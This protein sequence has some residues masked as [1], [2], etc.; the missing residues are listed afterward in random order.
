[1]VTR[2]EAFLD[3]LKGS[4]MNEKKAVTIH[5]PRPS[6]SAPPA[7][8]TL[9][10]PYMHDGAAFVAAAARSVGIPSEVLPKQTEVEIAL[11][12]KYTSSKECFPMICT[13]GSFLKKLM[14]PGADPSKM[15]FFMPDHNGPCR[16][17]QYNQF[18]RILFDRLGFKDAELVT[19]SNDTS[20]ADLAGDQSQK[21]RINAWKGF[22]SFDYVKKLYRKYDL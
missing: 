13:T 20:Y 9:Y 12:R 16:F 22:V 17:G 8:R 14:E 1:M 18:Q 19:P 15:S 5:R 11:G 6:P 7:N 10:F 21:F 3:S 2:I 4:E